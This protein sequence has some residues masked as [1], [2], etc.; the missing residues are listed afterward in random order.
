ML[1]A[2]DP[3]LESLYARLQDAAI[4]PADT[5]QLVEEAHAR[6]LD[7][8]ALAAVSNGGLPYPVPTDPISQGADAIRALA[9]AIDKQMPVRHFGY[10]Y[11]IAGSGAAWIVPAAITDVP[12]SSITVPLVAGQKYTVKFTANIGNP[13]SGSDRTVI[14]RILAAGTNILSNTYTV[15]YVTSSSSFVTAS[16]VTSQTAATTGNVTFVLQAQGSAASAVSIYDTESVFTRVI[17]P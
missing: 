10:Q 9:E 13:G 5:A 7:I 15:P 12:N 4:N 16:I 11:A 1:T 17:V 14:L 2:P 6:Y 8:T 3:Q